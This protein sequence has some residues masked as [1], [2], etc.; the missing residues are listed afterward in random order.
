MSAQA[1]PPSGIIWLECRRIPHIQQET[2]AA[3]RALTPSAEGVCVW[4]G[5]TG[6]PPGLAAATGRGLMMSNGQPVS[7]LAWQP[8]AGW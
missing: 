8:L 7:R 2:T 3:R 5:I 6:S 4:S 1:L